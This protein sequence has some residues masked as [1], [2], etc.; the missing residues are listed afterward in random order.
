MSKDRSDPPWVPGWSRRNELARAAGINRIVSVSEFV[1]RH[2][3]MK[4]MGIINRE[5]V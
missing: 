2:S 3:E 5:A 4:A 1:R